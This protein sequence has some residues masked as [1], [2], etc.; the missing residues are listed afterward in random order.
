MFGLNVDLLLKTLTSRQITEWLA[1]SQLEDWGPMA[2]MHQAG[3]ICA[4]I[5]NFA[6]L[7][8][9]KGSRALKPEDFFPLLKEARKKDRKQTGREID[10]ELRKLAPGAAPAKI[11][12][13]GP[14][15]PALKRAR[16]MKEERKA[17]RE[18]AVAEKPKVQLKGNAK[19]KK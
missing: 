6:G 5:A 1:Y 11:N 13:N 4:A 3:M 16:E 2:T 10:A 12:G 15:H 18:K 9:G 14:L 8:R 7:G 17:R 19:R